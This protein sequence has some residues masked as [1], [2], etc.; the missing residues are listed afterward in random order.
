MENM[1]SNAEEFFQSLE[2]PYRVVNMVSGEL[3]LAAAKK[4]D[5]EGWFPGFA[6]LSY[7]FSVIYKL[8]FLI[9][10]IQENFFTVNSDKRIL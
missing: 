9:F 1:I 6:G 8:S 10:Y 7:L 2:I 3:N 4:Y 5:L